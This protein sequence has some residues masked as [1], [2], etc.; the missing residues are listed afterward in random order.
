MPGKGTIWGLRL[1]FRGGE[2]SE[3]GGGGGGGIFLKK[4]I[5][6][7]VFFLIK[8]CKAW[9]DA[10][11]VLLERYFTHIYLWPPGYLCIYM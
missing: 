10:G 1:L 7:H 5:A 11:K 6:V 3:G 8:V 4:Y 9:E 2:G